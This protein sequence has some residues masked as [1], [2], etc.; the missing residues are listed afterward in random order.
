MDT[1]LAHRHNCF[2]YAQSMND[3]RWSL[4]NGIFYKSMRDTWDQDQ[5]D[6][7]W[8]TGCMVWLSANNRFYDDHP[9]QGHRLDRRLDIPEGIVKVEKSIYTENFEGS[10]WVSIAFKNGGD[11]VW[12]NVVR[13][14]RYHRTDKGDNHYL[15]RH[16]QWGMRIS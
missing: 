8:P 1:M 3:D 13:E 14:P 4:L 12:T 6:D 7:E 11:V 10:K 15:N 2:P 16:T 9:P 5:V